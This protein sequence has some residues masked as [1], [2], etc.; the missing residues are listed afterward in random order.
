MN[1]GA[2]RTDDNAVIAALGGTPYALGDGFDGGRNAF[3]R[4]ELETSRPRRFEL[5]RTY[6]VYGD[7]GTWPDGFATWAA[8]SGYGLVLSLGSGA[9]QTRYAYFETAYTTLHDATLDSWA[10]AIRAYVDTYL[11]ELL[12]FSWNHEPGGAGSSL[13]LTTTAFRAAG[14]TN[15]PV[16]TRTGVGLVKTLP[17]GTVLNFGG[18]ITATLS[19]QA[20]P[21]PPSYPAPTSLAVQALGA[22]IPSGSVC[23]IESTAQMQL[24]YRD[25]FAKVRTRM[26]ARWAGWARR[27]AVLFT[28]I[29]FQTGFLDGDLWYPGNAYVDVI[30]GD[31]YNRYGRQVA[32]PQPWQ[33]LSEISSANQVQSFAAGKGKKFIIAECGVLEGVAITP[34]GTYGPSGGQVVV[35]CQAIKGQADSGSDVVFFNTDGTVRF[36]TSLAAQATQGAV[37]VTL[38]ALPQQITV[39]D[40]GAARPVGKSKAAWWDNARAHLRD[41]WTDVVGLLSFNTSAAGN[42]LE[43]PAEGSADSLARFRAMTLDPHFRQDHVSLHDGRT[44]SFAGVGTFEPT[45]TE[46][47]MFAPTK[48]LGAIS[49]P[50]KT[51]DAISP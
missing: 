13:T 50:T 14:S 33:E 30:G 28:W 46:A 29:L 2:D 27:Y 26:D 48:P 45:K 15:L 3:L 18:G 1:S 10:D 6:S 8:Q 38:S 21:V 11:E 7:L 39:A 24:S 49:E 25:A 51:Y 31:L 4:L 20:D 12:Y 32:T 47:A 16:K 5:I 40:K 44:P 41:V 34:T 22:D 17:S 23:A 36:T 19:A 37:S 9:G 43:Q 35:G 42:W